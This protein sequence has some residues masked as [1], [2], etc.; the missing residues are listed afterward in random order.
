[1]VDRRG[2][3]LIRPIYEAGPLGLGLLPGAAIRKF[4]LLLQLSNRV[5]IPPLEKGPRAVKSKKLVAS[6]RQQEGADSLTVEG[7]LRLL[8][9]H[10]TQRIRARPSNLRR[11]RQH[12]AKNRVTL[13]RRF[14][15]SLRI[16]RQPLLCSRLQDPIFLLVCQVL[17]GILLFPSTRRFSNLAQVLIRVRT[18]TKSIVRLFLSA[19]QHCR[20]I[21]T[22]SHLISVL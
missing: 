17:R 15:E 16:S 13:S 12:Q 10:V 7:N 22:R 9:E 20:E 1:M 11:L 2:R 5:Q 18:S 6:L 14:N 19:L 21:S 4:P 8:T 3:H